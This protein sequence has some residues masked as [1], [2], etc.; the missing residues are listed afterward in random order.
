MR[1]YEEKERDEVDNDGMKMFK[2]LNEG[3]SKYESDIYAF[4]FINLIART[5]AFLNNVLE[6]LYLWNKN[7]LI[8]DK[9]VSYKEIINCENI[10][11]L[12]KGIRENAI[13]EFSHSSFKDKLDLLKKKFRLN[14]PY[15]EKHMP[16]IIELFTTR[17]IILH[18]NGIVNKTYLNINKNSEYELG[19]KLTINKEYIKLTFGLLVL[20]A[21]SI[22]D[23]INSNT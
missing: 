13:L 10:D 5:E 2:D 16:R 11:E 6:T 15:I 20:I 19:V 12:V 7:S 9:T 23:E 14:F 22:E 18:N 3:I 17:N 8:S 4:T 21:K 1:E